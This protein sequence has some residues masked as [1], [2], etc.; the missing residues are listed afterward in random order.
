MWAGSS[1]QVCTS[2][3]HVDTSWWTYFVHSFSVHLLYMRPLIFITPHFKGCCSSH[4]QVTAFVLVILFMP[5]CGFSPENFH[6]EDISS[7]LVIYFCSCKTSCQ[8]PLQ[9]F[10]NLS[11]GL[12]H[13]WMNG[14]SGLK[15]LQNQTLERCSPNTRSR[16]S[17]LLRGVS[18]RRFHVGSRCYRSGS[19]KFLE[20]LRLR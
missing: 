18:S 8:T 19:D 20:S 16:I 7:S 5:R 12:S 3:I 4:S 17:L 6:D 2:F 15:T 14:P 1:V 9:E 13:M 10:Y 11:V